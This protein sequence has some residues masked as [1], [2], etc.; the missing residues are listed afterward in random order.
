MEEIGNIVVSE[1]GL[2]SS[3]KI[4]RE[5][6]SVSNHLVYFLFLLSW[7]LQY[8]RVLSFIV[9]FAIATRPNFWIFFCC[10]TRWALTTLKKLIL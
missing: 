9:R 8:I 1:L 4:G 5:G 10:G 3:L 7:I 6:P 2:G